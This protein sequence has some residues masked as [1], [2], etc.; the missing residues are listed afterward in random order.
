VKLRTRALQRQLQ[1]ALGVAAEDLPAI[2]AALAD[3]DSPNGR[4]AS[5]RLAAALPRFLNEIDDSYAQSERDL[6]LRA[7][8]LELSSAE[9][10]AANQQL[11]SDAAAVAQVIH[12]LQISAAALATTPIHTTAGEAFNDVVGLSALIHRL[13]DDHVGMRTQLA[14]GEAKFQTVIANLPG[15]VYRVRVEPTVQLDFVSDGIE[16]F[17]GWTP[18]QWRNDPLGLCAQVGGPYLLRRDF[19]PV[20]DLAA[21]EAYEV[22]YQLRCADGRTRWVVERGRSY[23]SDDVETWWTAIILDNDVAHRAQEEIASTRARLLAARDQAELANRAKTEFLANM[24]HEI[25]TPLNGI[26][27]MIDLTLG[28]A[29]NFEQ[30]ENLQLARMSAGLLLEL[31]ND[32]LDLSKIESGKLDLDLIPFSVR[33]MVREAIRPTAVRA[34]E[35]GLAFDC[36]IAADVPDYVVSDPSKL[37]QVI[38]NLVS[39]AIKF[40]STGGVHVEV[41]AAPGRFGIAPVL[42]IAVFDT[43]IGI[44]PER[45]AAIFEAF[46]QAET[47]TNR[48][49]GGTGLGLTISRKLVRLL[50][51]EITVSS[52]RGEGSR[53]A[54]TFEAKPAEGDLRRVNVEADALM[55]RKILILDMDST[56]ATWMQRCLTHCGSLVDVIHDVDAAKVALAENHYDAVLFDLNFGRGFDCV[57]ELRRL[58]PDAAIVLLSGAGRRGDGARAQGAGAHA[59]LSKPLSERD[60]VEGLALSLRSISGIDRGAPVVTSHLLAE[61]RTRVRILVAEDNLVNQRLMTRLLEREGHSFYIAANGDEAV[62]AFASSIF[63]MVLLDIQMPIMD[64]LEAARQIRAIER[65]QGRRPTPLLALTANALSQSRDAC[66]AAG[67]DGFMTKPIAIEKLNREFARHIAGIRAVGTAPNLAPVVDLILTDG[68]SGELRQL[69]VSDSLARLD[70]L[71][72]ALMCGDAVTVAAQAHAIR[73]AAASMKAM[74]LALL[75]G[76]IERA[77]MS[78]QLDTISATVEQL[79]D[80]V[81]LLAGHSPPSEH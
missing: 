71:H 67:I 18:A 69:F 44:S 1:R 68:D 54:F 77:G 45:Q 52:I 29:L 73:G 51:G 19:G 17:I 31:I 57:A 7:R 30:H 60:L 28:T 13:I 5:A 12:N 37:R 72:A 55:E 39:N 23:C 33:G 36:T 47:T 15:C 26:L 16:Q 3:A 42:Q 41:T 59:Y 27:G 35:K 64:G 56:S 49:F 50:G 76:A 40:T 32:I 81:R 14:S 70:V 43:G 66:L 74:S 11:R 58:L 21:G 22:E 61:N 48:E 63:D 4:V 2:M 62:Q 10:T 80:G 20:Q 79:R 75:A 25:R 53:F 24:S 9:L 38:T 34:E 78:D 6:E 46:A 65:K 8:A